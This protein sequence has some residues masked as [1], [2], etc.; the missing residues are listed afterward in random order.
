MWSPY[1]V[2]DIDTQ[3]NV[4]RRAT[5]QIPSLR[6][7]SYDQR[8]R[9]LG[10]PTLAYR[11]LRGDMIELYKI[12]NGIYDKSVCS[13]IT[14][15]TNNL[16]TRG[17]SKKLYLPYARLNVRKNWF[18]I[19]NVITWNDLHE[20]IVNAPNVKTFEKRLD[21]YWRCEDFK[22]NYRAEAPLCRRRHFELDIEAEL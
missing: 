19:R 12:T 5:K 4:Q 15:N 11:R 20:Y 18:G 21:R 7:L 6:N 14:T 3:E 22:F 1:K 2:K 9:K 13:F 16:H 17:H 10:L 8:L